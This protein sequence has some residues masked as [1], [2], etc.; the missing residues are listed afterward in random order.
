MNYFY[1]IMMIKNIIASFLY[2]LSAAHTLYLMIRDHIR[3]I[4]FNYINFHLIYL[5]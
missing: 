5:I 3:A 1:L 4:L 2:I